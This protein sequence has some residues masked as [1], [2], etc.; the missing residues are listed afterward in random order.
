VQVPHEDT[1]DEVEPRTQRPVVD[2]GHAPPGLLV[3][4]VD[5]GL[6]A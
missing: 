5:G 3:Q 6:C 1:F 2:R 4:V